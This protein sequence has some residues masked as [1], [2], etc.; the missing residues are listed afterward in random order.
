MYNLA[1]YE[2]LIFVTVFV[3]RAAFV[4]NGISF[5]QRERCGYS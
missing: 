2:K 4:A 3:A 5:N 1:I